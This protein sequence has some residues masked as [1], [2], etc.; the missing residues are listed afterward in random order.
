M[1]KLDIIWITSESIHRISNDDMSISYS[2]VYYIQSESVKAEMDIYRRSIKEPSQCDALLMYRMAVKL[3]KAGSVY[4][5]KLPISISDGMSNIIRY[6]ASDIHTN[7]PITIIN[8]GVKHNT[9]ICKVKVIDINNKDY[10]VIKPNPMP[11]Q[12]SNAIL[13]TNIEQ[14]YGKVMSCF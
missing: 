1:V 2:S 9:L 5:N 8:N 11:I 14:F 13:T 3:S 12:S 4:K 10:I 6:I 7:I